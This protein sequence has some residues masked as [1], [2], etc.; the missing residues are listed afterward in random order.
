MG[1]F[2]EWWKKLSNRYRLVLINDETLEEVNSIRLTKKSLYI[3]LC[4]III[5][6][7]LIT[8]LLISVTPLRYYVPG[9][10]DKRQQNAYIKLNMK[11]DSLEMRLR[12]QDEYLRH[13]KKVLRGEVEPEDSSF[14]KD[15]QQNGHGE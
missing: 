15:V 8:G 10:G 4:T 6:L 13:I 3:T 12:T 14:Y 9:Y 7:L 2:R 5:S 11:I 1:R